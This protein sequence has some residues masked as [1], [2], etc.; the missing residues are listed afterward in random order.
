[1]KAIS[2]YYLTL[3]EKIHQHPLAWALLASF[4]LPFTILMLFYFLGLDLFPFGDGSLYTV[5]LGQQ[6]IDFYAYYRNVLLGQW[7]QAL[8]SFQKALGGEMVGTW[9]YY[10]MSPYLLILLLFPQSWMTLAV[11]LII[12]AKIATAGGTFQYLLGRLYGDVSWRSLAFSFAYALIG[13]VS[14]NHLNVMWLDGYAFLP[15]VIYGLE[16]LLKHGSWPVYILSLAYIL[17]SNYYM[18][19]MVC[20]FLILY[21]VYAL[22]RDFHKTNWQAS[23][24][25][26]WRFSWTS[27]AAAGLSAL[28]LL[29]TYQA[30]SL[31]KGTY[32]S[33]VNW[34]WELAYPIQDLLSKFYLAPFNFDQMPEGLPNVYI[35]SLGL[36]ALGLYFTQ[37][38]VS[39]QEKWGAGLVLLLLVLSMNIQAVNIIWHGFQ[40]PIWYPYR[41]SFVFSFFCLFLGY[42]GYRLLQSFKLKTALIFLAL[43]TASTVYVLSQSK[44]F[45]YLEGSHVL[46]S[47]VLF[48]LFSLAL[49]FIEGRPRWSTFLIY[50]LTV[51]ELSANSCLTLSSISYLSHSEVADYELLTKD[52]IEEIKPDHDDFYRI[53]KLFQRTKNDP[54]QLNYYG[55]S[56]FNSTIEKAS[57]ELYRYLGL[58]SSEG[59]VAYNNGS[60][61]TD[62]F[63]GARYIVESKP[64][65]SDDG[66]QQIH[67]QAASNRPDTKLYPLVQS[68]PHL[69]AYEND[70]ALPLAYSLPEDIF[71]IQVHNAYPILLQDQ[72]LQV[73]NRQDVTDYYQY[74]QVASFAGLTLDQVESADA[75]QINTHYRRS[76]DKG[77]AWIHFDIQVN[78]NDS[79]YLTVPGQLSEDDVAFYLD[80]EA[81]PY[82]KSF[83]SVQV[84]NIAAN[85]AG[86][87]HH[88]SIKLL[89]DDIDL[90]NVNLYRLNPEL[91]Q[92]TSS[93]VQ[94]IALDIDKFSN[95]RIEGQVENQE[96]QDW[97]VFSFP[98]NQNWTFTVDGEAVDSRPV[99]DGGFTAIPLGKA[100]KHQVKL[101]FWPS[102]LTGGLALSATTAAGLFTLYR[103]EK[104]DQDKA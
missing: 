74:F 18:G 43:F 93:Q 30:L 9:S 11:A 4:A 102:A 21:M 90:N 17:I 98:Y 49:F 29:P 33:E 14:A 35:G 41:F 68:D 95:R 52:F 24:K 28:V 6:Y 56:H 3:R 103:K 38:K 101:S 64:Q 62:A 15:L 39:R 27:L 45:D 99:L 51:I 85:E 70:N 20:L 36:I 96:D 37:K 71:D 13:Y 53:S 48:I 104:K 22:I 2:H 10:L 86:Q 40:P 26:V 59:F 80:G 50:L 57:T 81:M 87:R 66:T 78:S 83:N 31:S 63:F 67:L 42:R 54:M 61:V 77:D 88:F 8:Y 19:Y 55:L 72:L 25:Q 73:A 89:A 12:A 100:G 84:Y 79:Y 34:T 1:M 32:A 91:V 94:D 97:L 65:P 7:G 76:Q 16:R 58:P 82:E 46:A 44:R 5:D 47:F 23:L 69:M 75:K 60:L 92:G